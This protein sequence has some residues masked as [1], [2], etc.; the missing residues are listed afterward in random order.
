MPM[1]KSVHVEALPGAKTPSLEDEF[2]EAQWVQSLIDAGK[3]KVAGIVAACN[4]AQENVKDVLAKLKT[5]PS[6]RGIRY[7]LDHDGTDFDGNGKS[8][9]HFAVTRHGIDF[10]RDPVEAPKFAAGLKILG[11][12]GMTF[13]LQ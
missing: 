10:M 7:I 5:I 11:E 1:V 6:V 13:D 12:M 4:L 9:T 8:A 3:C 2:A